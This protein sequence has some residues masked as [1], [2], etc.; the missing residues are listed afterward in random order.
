MQYI[1][2]LWMKCKHDP[3]I[4][5]KTYCL[6]SDYIITKMANIFKVKYLK[7]NAF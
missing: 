2:V 5:I 3:K 1:N 4:S 7:N 6:A